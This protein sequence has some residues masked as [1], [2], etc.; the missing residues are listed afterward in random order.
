[1]TA[2]PVLAAVEA[3]P[4]TDPGEAAAP[5]A[6]SYDRMKPTE[7][8]GM[9]IPGGIGLQKQYSPLGKYGR[10]IHVPC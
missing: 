9:P 1:M 2:A 10:W 6:G 5:A 8:K 3:A 4:A 7:G